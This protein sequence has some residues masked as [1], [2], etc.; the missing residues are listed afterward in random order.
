MKISLKDVKCH[1]CDHPLLEKKEGFSEEVMLTLK[2]HHFFHKSCLNKDIK[3]H[4]SPNDLKKRK[5]TI[6]LKC[7][8]KDCQENILFKL[9]TN[10]KSEKGVDVTYLENISETKAELLGHLHSFS[11]E[12]E[13]KELTQEN[14]TKKSFKH[15]AMILGAIFVATLA[16]VMFQTIFA[17]GVGAVLGY[18]LCYLLD[19][20]I[21]QFS[22]QDLL[23]LPREAYRRAQ[24]YI[25]SAK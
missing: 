19:K 17:V 1:V 2:C 18:G 24:E 13:E 6:S 25:Q 3:N 7:P 5:E 16:G 4:L 22:L 9:K 8:D 14:E 12:I 21:E 15:Q 10:K 23:A 11:E 20:A